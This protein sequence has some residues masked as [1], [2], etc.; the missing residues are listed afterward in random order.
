MAAQISP[1]KRVSLKEKNKSKM[2]ISWKYLLAS[3]LGYEIY[4]IRYN[5]RASAS[6]AKL[7]IFHTS[8]IFLFFSFTFFFCFNMN[9]NLFFLITFSRLA[10]QMLLNMAFEASIAQYFGWLI[11]RSLNLFRFSWVK[12][13]L[14]ENPLITLKISD[15]LIIVHLLRLLRIS[16]EISNFFFNFSFFAQ[17]TLFHSNLNFPLH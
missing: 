14:S 4:V 12:W 11:G 3:I 13:Y 1:T 10:S 5:M 16:S 17:L 9:E 2:K 6:K 8:E 7:K 15:I